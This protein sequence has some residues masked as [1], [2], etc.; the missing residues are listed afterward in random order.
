MAEH[1][2]NGPSNCNGEAEQVWER[3]WTLDEMRKNSAS[4]S[5]AA[6]SGVF[7]LITEMFGVWS[8]LSWCM[9]VTLMSFHLDSFFSTC[10]TSLSGCC[11]RPMR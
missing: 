9:I 3:P 4:W 6:D 2:E 1:M 11:P 10:K 8:Y 5:L 7:T